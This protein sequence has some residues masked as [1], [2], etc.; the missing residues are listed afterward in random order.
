L[1]KY[2]YS[3]QESLKLNEWV[4]GKDVKDEDGDSQTDET[5]YYMGDPL[6]SAPHIITYGGTEEDPES[7]VFMGTNEGFLH[8]FDSRTGEEDFAFMPKELLPNLDLLFENSR[9]IDKV[10]GMDGDITSWINDHDDDGIIDEQAGDHAYIYA[11]MRRGG[12]NYYALDVTDRT[13]PKFLFQIPTVDTIAYAELGQSWS[14]PTTATIK[15]GSEVKEVL[16]FAGG[17]DEAQDD[18]KTYS[19]DTVGRAIFIADAEDGSLIWSG[20]P[21][22]IAGLPIKQF[23]KMQYSIP[24]NIKVVDPDGDGLASQLYVGDMGGQL[25]RF[26]INN[27]ETGIDLVDGGVIAQFGDQTQAGARRF[28]HEPDLVLTKHNGDIKLSIGI[29]SGYQAHPLDTVID[30]RYYQM[31]YPLQYTGNY[32][33]KEENSNSYRVITETDLYDTTD[34]LIGE[35]TETEVSDARLALNDSE[36]WYIRM[37][38]PGEKILGSSATLQGVVRF[39][40]YLPPDGTGDICTPDIG[41]SNYFRV[42]LTDG[43]PPEDENSDGTRTKQDRSND[44]PGGGIAPAVTTVFVSDPV[45]GEVNPNDVSGVNVLREGDNVNT[46]KRRYWSE[47][48]E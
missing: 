44:I 36:G 20:Q 35:G 19:D 29:G 3:V 16:I 11:G 1:L 18:K 40:S 43:T 38:R 24:S 23:P 8:A 37:E 10:Y 12:S 7:V 22:D 2:R 46:V 33:L 14:R 27:G 32:G 39:V 17:Y 45:T 4:R 28:F 31:R 9:F 34:N 47:K 30:D 42:S 6:H 5:R 15:V 13:D 41:S 21:N 48:P 26:D 25:W